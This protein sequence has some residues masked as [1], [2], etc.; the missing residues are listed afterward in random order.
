MLSAF[1]PELDSS[2]HWTGSVAAA[3]QDRTPAASAGQE[4]SGSAGRIHNTTPSSS[5]SNYNSIAQPQH[6]PQQH[7]AA[8]LHRPQG[9]SHAAMRQ[10]LQQHIEAAGSWQQLQQLLEGR[11]EQLTLKHI[12]T[13]VVQVG[14]LVPVVACIAT[15]S[16]SLWM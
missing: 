6:K 4:S 9:V 8:A 11:K 1:T 5:S 3:D 2:V 16:A 13:M 7:T 14:L 10:L 12:S 15:L